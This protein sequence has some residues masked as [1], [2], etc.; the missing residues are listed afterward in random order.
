MLN[1]R[2]NADPCAGP[3]EERFRPSGA[4]WNVNKKGCGHLSHENVW[5]IPQIYCGMLHQKYTGI[6]GVFSIYN[7]TIALGNPK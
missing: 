7:C 1:K 3:V 4:A 2:K 5:H 6:I